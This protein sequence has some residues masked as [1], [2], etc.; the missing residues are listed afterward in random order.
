MKMRGRHSRRHRICCCERLE[1][2]W[3]LA[4]ASLNTNLLFNGDAEADVGASDNTTIVN[5]SDW[6]LN[7]DP[8]FTAVK[9]GASGG[10]PG[11]SV[12]GPADRGNNFFAGG[13]NNAENIV[14]QSDDISA[15]ANGIDA[16]MIKATLTGCLGGWAAE[17]DHMDVTLFL[18]ASLHPPAKH[19]SKP[20]WQRI[21]TISL[22]LSSAA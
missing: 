19:P 14:S 20:C 22:R 7:S 6:V 13:S 11:V 3:L 2:R 17:D 1:S 5:P 15:L 12:P 18:A 10:L 16:G 8:D 21:E 4:G 9:Y